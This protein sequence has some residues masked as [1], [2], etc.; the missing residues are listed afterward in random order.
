MTK[1]SG[2]DLTTSIKFTTKLR[3]LNYSSKI[4]GS[5]WSTSSGRGLFIKFEDHNYEF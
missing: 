5:F 2:Y 1:V 3:V 4:F